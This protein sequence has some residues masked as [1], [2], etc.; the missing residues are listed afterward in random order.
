[1]NAYEKME[2][3]VIGDE[4]KMEVLS[5]IKQLANYANF[6]KK[7]EEEKVS[8]QEIRKLILSNTM[9]H[10]FSQTSGWVRNVDELAFTAITDKGAVECPQDVHHYD[11]KYGSTEKEGVGCAEFLANL[12]SEGKEIKEIIVYIEDSHSQPN[13]YRNHHIVKKYRAPFS[14]TLKS[15]LLEAM[16]RIVCQQATTKNGNNEIK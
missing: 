1:M 8:E 6:I 16:K 2:I 12:V 4:E 13:D 3:I 10:L 7:I 14:H 5:E 11:I 15:A 9:P